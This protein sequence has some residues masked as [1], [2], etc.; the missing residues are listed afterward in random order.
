M[1]ICGQTLILIDNDATVSEVNQKIIK[2]TIKYMLYHSPENRAYCISTYGHE[3]EAEE[4]FSTDINDLLCKV[5]LLEFSPKDSNLTDVLADTITKWRE[6]DFGCRDILVFTDGLEGINLNYED[7]ELF[8]LINNTSYPIYIVN[9]V[10]DNN[11]SVR[12]H[13]S[14]ISTTSEGKL[15]SSEFPGDDGGVDRQLSEGIFAQMEEYARREWYE[16]D[17]GSVDNTKE[18]ATLPADDKEEHLQDEEKEE[19]YE[20]STDSDAIDSGMSESGGDISDEILD[21]NLNDTNDLMSID[22]NSLD[23]EIIYQKTENLEFY[24]KPENVI[25]MLLGIIILIIVGLVCSMIFIRKRRKVVRQSQEIQDMVAENVIKKDF[26]GDEEDSRD[27]FNETFFGDDIY[28]DEYEEHE[29]E[30]RDDDENEG[31][32]LLIPVEEGNETV[33]LTPSYKHKLTFIDIINE[34]NRH[35]IC[36]N[37]EVLIGRQAAACDYVISD[38]SVSKRHC[39]IIYRNEELLIK[40][41]DSSNGTIVNGNKIT[42]AIIKNGD[43]IKL[44]ESEYRM[45][46]E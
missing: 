13:L 26:F 14:A 34:N 27:C 33:L 45:R 5:D 43:K 16:S 25:S 28:S 11:E 18:N 30:Q 6:A 7:E 42:S 3:I 38:A 9:L 21:D 32:R 23:S 36:F 1:Q 15:F 4:E 12:K 40:D 20:E 10:Q 39:K 22:E 37:D 29:I 19:I 8:Y 24:E 17:E 46:C 44:G 35:V 31:T 2:S 41:L